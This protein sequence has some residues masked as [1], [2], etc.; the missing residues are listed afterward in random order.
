MLL[1]LIIT[2]V[3]LHGFSLGQRPA[4]SEGF[5]HFFNLE[6]PEAIRAFEAEAAQ[7]PGDPNLHN[8]IAQAILYREMLRAGALESELVSGTNPFIGREKLQTTSAAASQFDAAVNKAFE[9]CRARLASNPD[10]VGALYAV[11]VSHGLRSNYNF[12]VRKAWLDSLKDATAGRK[13]HNRVLELQPDFIDARVA[14]GVHDYIVGSLP[15]HYKLL[16]F[17]TG[18]R[19]DREGGIRTL[20][21]VAEQGKLN[22]YDAK[23]MLAAIYRRERKPELALPLVQELSAR[24]P[25]NYLFRLEEVQM[26]SDLGE[27][28]K[29]LGALDRLEAAKKSGARGLAAMPIEKVY[30]Y[31]GNLLFWYNDFEA[32]FGQLRNATSGSKNLD[33]HTSVMAWMR[34]GQVND[35]RAR[36]GDAVAAYKEA[37]SIAPVSDVAKEAKQYLSSPYRRG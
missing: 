23:V 18:F 32:A 9:L 26:Y 6:F 35:L 7:A 29:A 30:Y 16:G 17:L 27:K 3:A 15:W 22:V 4:L 11:G 13:A 1:R 8:H 36:R 24:F 34:L 10:D 19:G 5:E 37:V 28:E 20:R 12:L 2:A 21:S 25:R 31:R 14:Q 33:L